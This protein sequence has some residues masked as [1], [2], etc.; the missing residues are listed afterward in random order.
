MNKTE[1][2]TNGEM[3]RADELAT[4]SG[5]DLM[6]AAGRSVFNVLRKTWTWRRVLIICGPGN[7][8]GDGFVVARLLWDAGWPVKVYL[9]G[10][11]NSLKGEAATAAKLWKGETCDVSDDLFEDVD[12][13]VDAIFGAGI[14]RNVTGSL[15][16]VFEKI[17]EHNL[18]CLSIDMPSGVDG[19]TGEIKGCALQARKTVTFFRKKPGHLL[20]PGKLHCGKLHLADIGIPSSVLNSIKPTLFENTPANWLEQF[21]FPK[22]KDH[23]YSRGHAVIS[24]GTLMIGAARLAAN[25][26]RRV[27]AGLTT[28]I[29]D[30]VAVDHYIGGNL[31]DMYWP[32][33]NQYEFHNFIKEP[34][35][36]AVLIGP[37]NGVNEETR[38]KVITTL[39]LRKI[40]VLDADALTIF[41][42]DPENLFTWIKG[43]AVLTPHEGEFSRLF[44]EPDNRLKSCQ[45]AA[46]RSGAVVVLK[47]PDTVIAAP[48]GRAVINGNAPPT[49]ATAGS[50]DALAGFITGLL[51]Q[52]MPAFESACAGVWLH[53]EA[54]RLFGIGLTAEDIIERMPEVLAS[55]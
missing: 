18:D 13:I 52:G 6:E 5:T 10:D 35:V 51:C 25:A 38:K 48:D 31:G 30:K 2:L 34:R 40:T 41:E 1:L 55:L 37:G 8:G 17:A 36:K 53:G 15:K 14:S 28:I 19:N 42:D 21:P 23:K 33:S 45:N 46:E 29:A 9:L 22:F 44:G 12:L 54:A 3:R 50:G 16:K 4:M 39:R 49:L 26:A 7:N 32:I 24:G 43:F 47:G 11:L 27:G 20:F